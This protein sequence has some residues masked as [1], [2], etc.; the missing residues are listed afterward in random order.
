MALK[1][2][3]LMPS[4][5]YQ[6]ACDA[7]REVTGATQLIKSGEMAGLIRSVQAGNEKWKQNISGETFSLEAADFAG[8]TKI[9]ESAFVSAPLTTVEI[10]ETITSIGD[11]AFEYSTL[12]SIWF[13]ESVSVIPRY[14]CS[15]SYVQSAHLGSLTTKISDGAFYS[16]DLTYVEIPILVSSIGSRAFSTSY[17]LTVKMLRSTPPAIEA[18]TFR[19]QS[20]TQIIVPKGASSAYKSAT[21]WSAFAGFIVEAT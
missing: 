16:S 18:D 6:D 7:I 11:F 9:R 2:Y 15:N 3:A 17:G 12:T 1:E 20:L 8:V 10:P 4:Q 5:D 21:N 14:V 19:S 13:P